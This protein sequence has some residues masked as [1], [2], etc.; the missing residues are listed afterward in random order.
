MLDST[1]MGVSPSSSGVTPPQWAAGL[2][3]HSRSFDD[4]FDKDKHVGGGRRCDLERHYSVCDDR[5]DLPM[6]AFQQNN[7]AIFVTNDHG[8]K[9]NLTESMDESC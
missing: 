7:P 1:S 6:D 9:V 2:L 8:D 3:V 4:A 5:E